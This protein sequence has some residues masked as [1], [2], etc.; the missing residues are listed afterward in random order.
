MNWH[1]SILNAAVLLAAGAG[2]AGAAAPADTPQDYAYVA[3][4]TTSARQGVLQLR[5]P[6]DVYLHA[7]SAD[8]DD[9][10]VFDATGA[11]LP[12]A[13]RNPAAQRHTSHRSLPLKIFPLLADPEQAGPVAL[14]V[15]T[16]NDGQLLS[17]QW[18][19]ERQ[20]VAGASQRL[21]ALILDLGGASEQRPQIDALRFT[22]P[23]GL[24]AYTAEVWLDTSDDLQHWDAAGTAELNWLSNQQAQTLASDRLN[25]AP[26]RFRYARLSWRSGTPQLFASI[27]ADELLQTDVAPTTETLVLPPGPGKFAGDLMYT[28][29]L[30]IPVRKV[31]LQF[32]SSSTVLPVTLGIYRELPAL[33]VGQSTSWR[34]DPVLSATF[35]RITQD[36]K[37]RVSGAVD[38]A[39]QHAARWAL[40][41]AGAAGV[42]PALQISWEP[43]SMVFL[44]NG[45]APY[46]LA[47]GHPQAAPAARAIEQ[48]APGFTVK[49]LKALEVA[50]AA[51]LRLQREPAAQAERSVQQASASA[52]QRIILLWG[53][54]LAGVGVL[55]F[56]VWRLLQQ[57]ATKPGP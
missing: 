15:R 38:I 28:A 55:A 41:A 40:R 48:V 43:A 50:T 30:A 9:V 39:P 12:F 51:P 49:E 29:P 37:E 5:L 32:T 23:A 56:M 3:P 47:V 57:Q 4:L 6:Q 31:G 16:S 20:S 2:P 8:L 11:A 17:V 14:D 44:A 54:L 33:Q 25:F 42:H 27:S 45:K 53:V 26:R 1:T 22:L 24:S 36:G 18:R 21:T 7:R 46:S 35:Y 52:R 13:L 19:P 10:R 34:F